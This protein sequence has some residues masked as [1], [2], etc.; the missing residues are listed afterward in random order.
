[1]QIENIQVDNKE[2]RFV[3]LDRIARWLDSRFVIPGTKI[4]FGLD[5]IISFIPFAGDLVTVLISSVLV[6]QMNQYGAS[7]K[8]VIKMMGNV[9][10][11]AVVGAIPLI[12]VVFDL[13]YKANDRNVKLLKEH[14]LEGK[15]QGSGTGIIIAFLLLI[16][17]LVVGILYLFWLLLDYL[18]S[19]F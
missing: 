3:L 12:G 10:V 19:L 16:I 6:Y 17:L 4:R 18:F 8:L 11:D 7:R 9:L 1:M 15:H 13:I 14:Y 2:G 5:P